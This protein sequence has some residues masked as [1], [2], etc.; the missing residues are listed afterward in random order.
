VTGPLVFLAF[1]CSACSS[2]TGDNAKPAAEAAP[3]IAVAEAPPSPPP[4]KPPRKMP[5]QIDR[6]LPDAAWE[7]AA[8]AALA[9]LKPWLDDRPSFTRLVIKPLTAP[10]GSRIDYLFAYE[11]FAGTESK[12]KGSMII[13]DG[14]LVGA[15]GQAD[16]TR[17]LH[18]IGFPAKPIDRGL[19]LEVLR[20]GEV[21]TAGW[22]SSPSAFG[23]QVFEDS[24]ARLGRE[25]GI[26]AYDKTGATFTL[27]RP[28]P[29]QL[30]EERNLA[31]RLVLRFDKDAKI[32]TSSAR[33]QQDKSWTP[34]PVGP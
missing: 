32:T 14:K 4:A 26:V 33:E 22:G 21:V 1:A 7:R 17:Y 25:R 15:G 5:V 16:V 34:I 12:Y 6:Q 10:D 23:W 28:R 20:L 31:D 30:L 19:L 2:H 29:S 24:G 11:A 27:Y 18:A 3:P 8:D 13:S 9:L